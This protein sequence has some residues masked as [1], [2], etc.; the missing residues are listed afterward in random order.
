M[1]VFEHVRGLMGKEEILQT[2]IVD[3]SMIRRFARAVGDFNPLYWKEEFAAGSRYR[4]VIAPPT[5]I[6]EM[7]FN[8]KGDVSEEDGSY[9]EIKLGLHRVEVIRGG[10]EYEILQP[11]R[12]G[13][14]IT[15]TRK[16]VDAYE[17]EGKR[18]KLVFVVL[19]MKY[20]NQDK[21]HV[22]TN[23]EMLILVQPS[24]ADV[25]KP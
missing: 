6:F 24:S 12:A 21:V 7:N 9:P 20:F 18:G 3:S 23:R 4:G 17:K 11:V 22:G 1:S 14:R 10:N 5:M 2:G 15:V 8:E 16:V 19:E 13:D 25:K